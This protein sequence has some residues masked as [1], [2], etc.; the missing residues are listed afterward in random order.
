[1]IAFTVFF[2]GGCQTTQETLI[3]S[4]IDGVIGK[5]GAP[6]GVIKM[7]NGGATYTFSRIVT[8]FAT[9]DVYFCKQNYTTDSNNIVVSTSTS[10]GFLC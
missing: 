6:D 10:G 9:G 2:A 8:G 3:G 7:Q 4:H 1:M 5:S